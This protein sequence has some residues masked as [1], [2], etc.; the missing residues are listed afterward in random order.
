MAAGSQAHSAH[1]GGGVPLPPEGGWV[2]AC[3]CLPG[4]LFLPETCLACAGSAECGRCLLGGLSNRQWR[5]GSVSNMRPPCASPPVQHPGAPA[6]RGALSREGAA[7]LL[8][9]ALHMGLDPAANQLQEDLDAGGWNRV[10]GGLA[11]CAAACSEPYILLI[12][13]VCV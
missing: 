7:D 13:L 2:A 4:H 6:A 11:G 10:V 5:D 9:A 8:L 3:L 1:H 12:H